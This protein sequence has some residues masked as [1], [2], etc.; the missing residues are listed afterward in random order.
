MHHP[1]GPRMRSGTLPNSQPQSFYFPEDHPSMPCW[2]KGMEVI[3]RER[4]LWPKQDE[5]LLT[6]CPGFRCPPAALTVAAGGSF[7]C[8]PISSPKSPSFKSWSNLAAIS[9]ISTQN[10]TASSTSSSNIGGQRSS[11]SVWQGAL[12]HSMRWRAR[13]SD[14]LMMSPSFTFGGES[15]AFLFRFLLPHIIF[16]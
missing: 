6:Q 1:N 7:L 8:S 13:S 3:I 5:D 14:A 11:V 2:F 10:T 4:G 15:S 9:A 12:Q 16:L